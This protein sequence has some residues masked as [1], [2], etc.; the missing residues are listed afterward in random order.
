VKVV[1]NVTVAEALMVVNA[2]MMG[3]LGGDP[4]SGTSSSD[5]G[6]RTGF[7]TDLGI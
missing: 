7:L 1:D 4:G 5:E 2:V 6:V 3:G